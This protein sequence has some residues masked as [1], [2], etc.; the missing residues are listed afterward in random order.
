M[1]QGVGTPGGRV[2]VGGGGVF[3]WRGDGVH[4]RD[5]AWVHHGVIGPLTYP[6]GCA[7]HLP[8][9]Q[10]SEA[11]PSAGAEAVERGSHLTLYQCEHPLQATLLGAVSRQSPFVPLDVGRHH[12]VVPQLHPP[13]QFRQLEPT[14]PPPQIQRH[15]PSRVPILVPKLRP[16]PS[17][18][19]LDRTDHSLKRR[20]HCQQPPRPTLLLLISA[21]PVPQWKE[22]HISHF[23]VERGSH[24]TLRSG[25][26]VTS[27]TLSMRAPASG[28]LSR[29]GLA[30]IA[31]RI[32]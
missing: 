26:R 19:L 21:N 18:D 23:A 4:R 30:P 7:T 27:H 13:G 17:F 10:A 22:G 5:G 11:P 2:R 25:K 12:P 32:A 28:D 29:R 14:Q 16:L 31:V 9:N 20:P 6:P 8:S 1:P 15:I 24:L 3:L